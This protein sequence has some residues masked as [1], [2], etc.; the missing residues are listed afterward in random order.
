MTELCWK[1]CKEVFTEMF[2]NMC[3]LAFNIQSLINKNILN[4]FLIFKFRYTNSASCIRVQVWGQ[5]IIFSRASS[6]KILSFF[7]FKFEFAALPCRRAEQ[8]IV[9]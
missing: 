8:T 9:T 4:E 7:E 2:M 3:Y 1:L 5:Q 6:A